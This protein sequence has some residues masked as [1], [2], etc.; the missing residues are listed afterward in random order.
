MG[1]G[2]GLVVCAQP[3]V[4]QV[5][6]WSPSGYEIMRDCDEIVARSLRHEEQAYGTMGGG[7]ETCERV[8]Q[9]GLTERRD[10]Q[11]RTSRS[12]DLNI[13]LSGVYAVMAS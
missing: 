4:G 7:M 11:H 13:L 2:C 1:A 12:C 10:P 8:G 3:Q 6:D 9:S 5:G